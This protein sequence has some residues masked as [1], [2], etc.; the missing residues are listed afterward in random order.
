MEAFIR[1]IRAHP[2]FGRD[3]FIVFC[4]ERN[5]GQPGYLCN[6]VKRACDGYN[7]SL[8]AEKGDLDYGWMMTNPKKLDMA[9]T[10]VNLLRI[11]QPTIMEDFVCPCPFDKKSPE[12]CRSSTIT[13]VKEQM[14]RKF[15]L[16]LYI[17]YTKTNYPMGG[18]K[19]LIFNRMCQQL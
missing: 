1:A 7:Y 19:V 8:I 4:F 13:K 3:C 15:F 14:F 6:V 10:M 12:E 2:F 9:F 5:L 11:N 16:S 18:K 17:G